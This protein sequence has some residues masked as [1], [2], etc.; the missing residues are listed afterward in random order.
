VGPG[1]PAASA[2]LQ[3]GTVI[4]GADTMTVVLAD[5]LGPAIDAHERGDQV[6]LRVR[7]RSGVVEGDVA[8]D[9]RPPRRGERRAVRVCPACDDAD[10]VAGRGLASDDDGVGPA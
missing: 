5:D 3:S 1:G 7:G 9:P 8:E 10:A 2:G 6:K 4:I